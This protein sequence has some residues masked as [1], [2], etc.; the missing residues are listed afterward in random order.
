MTDGDDHNMQHEIDN[1]AEKG[2][3]AEIDTVIDNSGIVGQP[4]AAQNEVGTGSTSA[5]AV[6][7]S[8]GTGTTDTLGSDVSDMNSDRGVAETPN[9]R[10]GD[11]EPVT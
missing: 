9:V 5:N 8:D 1:N 3:M 10:R 4:P 11:S 6:Y 2:G 7:P